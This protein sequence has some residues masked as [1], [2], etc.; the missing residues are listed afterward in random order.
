MLGDFDTAE[1]LRNAFGRRADL[2]MDAIPDIPGLSAK[3]P[4][5]GMFIMVDVAGTGLDGDAFAWRLLNEFNVA[6]MPGQSFGNEAKSLVR[7]ALTVPDETLTEA[8][9]RISALC[10]MLCS[11]PSKQGALSVAG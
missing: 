8:I 3:R 2:V 7:P 1:K 11:A 5:G 9:V 10:E 6:V 4:Q